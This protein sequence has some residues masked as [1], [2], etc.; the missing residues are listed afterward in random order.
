M[1]TPPASP[2][3][4]L[5]A[6]YCFPPWNDAAAVVAA[7]RVREAG[8]PV[9]VI[10]NAMDT[11][12]ERD[13]GLGSIAGHLVRRQQALATPTAFSSWAS[14]RDFT[15]A[16]VQVA[17][18]WERES[19]PH[20]RLYSR[21]QFAASHVL[22][23]RLVMLRPGLRWTAEFSDPLSHDVTGAVRH[24]PMGADDLALRLA[25]G[26]RA[27]GLE[28]PAGDN[29]FQWCEQ[30]A[31]GLADEVVFTNEHQAELMLGACPD[32]G[33]ARRA[34]QR[35]T[36]SPHPTLPEEFYAMGTAAL[37]LDPARRHLGY[38]GN[39]YATR[40]LGVVLDA[41]A[42]LPRADRDRVG[43]HVF[44]SKP[45]ELTEAV[46]ARG[47]DDCVRPRPFVGFLDFLALSR[48][49]D[50]L[51][52]S[53][54][55]TPA[56]APG[57]PFLPSKWSDYVGS[58]TPVWGIVEEGSPLSARPLTHRSPVGHVTAAQQVLSRVARSPRGG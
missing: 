52:V 8:E 17:L 4:T 38:F 47:L 57:N 24:A 46:T 39:F 45:A 21:A 32:R 50:C 16:G 34:E 36:I 19:G 3:R 5:V 40:G 22:A 42:G 9:D 15:R 41:L 7:K 55:H 56:G 6:S 49:L 43:L 13:E 30:L 54:A 58:G 35:A 27:R 14:I 53:D 18:L 48:Q 12:R 33:L 10:C 37:E 51:L 20:E 25:A 1:S 28:P 11:I 31:F 2:A 23:G 29:V 44:T 26:F